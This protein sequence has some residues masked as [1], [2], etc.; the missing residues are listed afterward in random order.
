MLLPSY[1]YTTFLCKMQFLSIMMHVTSSPY[2][3]QSCFFLYLVLVY[4]CLQSFLSTY[5]SLGGLIM[6]PFSKRFLIIDSNEKKYSLTAK[7]LFEKVLKDTRT[8]LNWSIPV[9]ELTSICSQAD[10]PEQYAQEIKIAIISYFSEL[11]TKHNF[12]SHHKNSDE[13]AV[14]FCYN[15]LLA[16]EPKV[17]S[18]KQKYVHAI[19]EG[20]TKYH[21]TLIEFNHFGPTYNKICEEWK[22]ARFQEFYSPIIDFPQL[23]SVLHSSFDKTMRDAESRGVFKL[24][25]D[26]R[27]ENM[28]IFL[29][30]LK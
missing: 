26:K 7:Q 17:A 14:Y 27:F 9:S 20:V 24:E 30:R 16:D 11:E 12:P 5:Q 10:F 18:V 3:K 15:S 29:S 8:N 28:H 25:D 1:N 4:Q 21:F 6:W 19:I 13:E 2:N 22:Q 23:R